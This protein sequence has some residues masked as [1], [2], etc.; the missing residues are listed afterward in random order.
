[1]WFWPTLNYTRPVRG[2]RDLRAGLKATLLAVT[3]L[4]EG[5]APARFNVLVDAD[6]T[7][8]VLC[9]NHGAPG[10]AV[11]RRQNLV[12]PRELFLHIDLGQVLRPHGQG[13]KIHNKIER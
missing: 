1:M 5:Q 9:G 10:L 4:T 8:R 13:L 2:I 11:V 7:T 12:G 3:R 6:Q